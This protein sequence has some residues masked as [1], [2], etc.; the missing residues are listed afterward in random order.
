VNSFGPTPKAS[1]Y[2]LGPKASTVHVR[3]MPATR[4]GRADGAV[5]VPCLRAV[6]RTSP[7]DQ[8]TRRKEVAG[9]RTNDAQATHR[10]WSRGWVVTEA[11]GRRGSDEDGGAAVRS[12]Q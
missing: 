7:T 6:A 2:W 9:A 8:P 3:P 1:Y 5:T 11:T 12:R 4:R 10:A